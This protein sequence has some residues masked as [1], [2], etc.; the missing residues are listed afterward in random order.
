MG[1]ALLVDSL[2]LYPL[3]ALLFADTGL[4]GAEIS[5]LLAIWS[6]TSLVVEVPSG[7]LADRF[8][9]RSCLVAASLFQGFGFA[10]WMALPGFAGF[11]AGFVAWGIGGALVTGARE[12]LLYDGLVAA[13][14]REEYA[15]VNGW[16]SAAELV[17]QIPIAATGS[18]L[19]AVGGYQLAGWVS[20]GICTAAAA[21]A[22]A[23]PEPP[24]HDDESEEAEEGYFATLRSGVMEAARRPAVRGALVAVA[25]LGCFDTV[26]EYF[27][28]ILDGWGVPTGLIPVAVLP[29]VLA[30]VACSAVAGRGKNL[31]PWALACLVGGG[32]LLFAGAGALAHPAGIAAIALFYGLYR[33]VLVIADARLQDRIETSARATVTSVAGLG[34]EIGSFGI[35]AAWAL[36]EVS[37]IATVGLLIAVVMPWLLRLGVRSRPRRRAVRVR[38]S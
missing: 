18:I 1:W 36:G 27:P 15:R 38:R 35:Y 30:G 32:V 16:L 28:L 9:R 6:V 34:T 29:I 26:E 14:V 33:G 11:A 5:A 31:P 7:A 17:A 3:Y 25:L 12:A 19:Y 8:S 2:P 37:G 4:S 10:L 23:I 21:L 20:V 24:R 13:G 22:A